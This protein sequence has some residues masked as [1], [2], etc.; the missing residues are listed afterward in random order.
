[1][2][3]YL[4]IFVSRDIYGYLL[5]KTVFIPVISHHQSHISMQGTFYCAAKIA[6]CLAG[7]LNA[8]LPDGAAG[9]KPV[10][11]ST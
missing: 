10:R 8:M 4:H 2:N 9:V 1:M 7:K 6:A 3:I 11:N 5:K